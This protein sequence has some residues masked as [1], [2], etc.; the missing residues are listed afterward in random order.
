MGDLRPSVT[1]EQVL[2]LLSQ[3]FSMLVTGLV[4]LDGGSV[5]RTFSFQADGQ[6]YV[7]RFNLDKMLT[8]NFPKELYVWRKLAGTDI[9]MAPM[10]EVGRMNDLHFA[11]SRKIPGKT[12]MQQKPGE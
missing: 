7:V 3:Y 6:E 9:P 11:I 4:E 2:T 5:A 8:S 12:L 1:H 10:I